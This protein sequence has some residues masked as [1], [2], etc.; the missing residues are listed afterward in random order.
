MVVEHLVN[1]GRRSA[2]KRTAHFF[3][4]LRL[5]IVGVSALHAFNCPLDQSMVNDALGLPPI[6][7][8]RVLLQLREMQLLTFKNHV[9]TIR[10]FTALKAVAGF[11]EQRK[12]TT[13]S[14]KF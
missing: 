11:R 12:A 9:V 2:I 8:N 3:R 4:T 14:N 6:H 7:V 5:E 1:V 13:K 10:D